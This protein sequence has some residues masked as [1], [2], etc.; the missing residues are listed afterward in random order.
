[1]CTER[2]IHTNTHVHTHMYTHTHTHT[3]THTESNTGGGDLVC[4]TVL[5]RRNVPVSVLVDVG[6]QSG[7]VDSQPWL[8][9]VQL[10]WTK[11]HND[12]HNDP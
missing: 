10:L 4:R 5:T 6:I 8:F 3:H 1:M 12:F 7:H 2:Q 9:P 11:Q